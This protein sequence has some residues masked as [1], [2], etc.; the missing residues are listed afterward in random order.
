MVHR[1]LIDFFNSIGQERPIC[2]VSA[3]SACQPDSGH[4]AAL[5]PTA[6]HRT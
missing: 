6:H 2:D 3:M 1:S 5:Q 4:I